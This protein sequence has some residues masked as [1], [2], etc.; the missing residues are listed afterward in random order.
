MVL[1][2][3]AHFFSIYPSPRVSTAVVE[4]YNS[5]L[6]THSMLE[7]TDVS[8]LVDNEALYDICRSRLE[9]QSPTYDNLNRLVAQVISSLTASLR[10]TGSLNVDLNEFQTNLVPYPRIHFPLVS[11]SPMVSINKA[12]HETLSVAEL[13]AAVFSPSNMMV[14]CDPRRGKYMACTLLYRG[15]VTPND[16]SFAITKI[17]STKRTV[18]FCSWSPTG[19]KVGINHQPPSTVPGGDLAA[20][21]RACCLL[22]NTTAIVEAWSRLNTKFDM[23]YCK[24]AFIHWFVGEGM[25]EATFTEAREDLMALE[26][27]YQSVLESSSSDD[28][29]YEESDEDEE[30]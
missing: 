25:E 16:V 30:A 17:K 23:M 28:E 12:F 29:G 7:H 8:F 21:P 2:I 22:G 26:R 4:P 3:V 10:F 1:Q 11:Y 13:T 19:F 15:D 20:V 6:S 24:R 18:Q 14:K 9:I 5:V 27:D